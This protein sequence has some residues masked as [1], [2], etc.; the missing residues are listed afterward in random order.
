MDVISFIT[1]LFENGNNDINNLR[2]ELFKYGIKTVVDDSPN[3]RI[4]LY[5][6]RYNH[7]HQIPR[8]SNENEVVSCDINPGIFNGL[9]L[10]L[11]KSTG[12]WK[13]CCVPQNKFNYSNFSISQEID[14]NIQDNL[15]NIYELNDGT[16]INLYWWSE[17]W[18]ISTTRGIQMN[19]VEW[20]HISYNTILTE[21]LTHY[22]EFVWDKLDKNKTY[23]IGFNHPKFHQFNP[24]GHD[25]TLF[26]I[27]PGK[28]WF[29]QSV[30]NT[31][32][33]IN[34][35]DDIKLP[36]Q[37]L[38]NHEGSLNQLK[39]YCRN[40][41]D[42]Y[43]DRCED[44]KENF[45]PHFGFT[46]VLKD[47]SNLNNKSHIMI[48]SSLFNKIKYYMYSGRYKKI[49]DDKNY[50]RL[51]YIILYSYLTGEVNDT[52]SVFIKLFPQFNLILEKYDANINYIINIIAKMLS[53]KSEMKK[54][55]PINPMNILILKLFKHVIVII[56][57]RNFKTRKDLKSEIIKYIIDGDLLSYYYPVFG[58][59]S[60]KMLNIL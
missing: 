13:V 43:I 8:H 51:S 20:Q 53:H 24:S 4:I 10:C 33:E 57:G 7:V 54:I 15:Y 36:L 40:S 41:M 44:K 25:L 28:L 42:F 16:T 60:E 2:S 29:I 38:W 56:G 14:S 35:K 30:H 48:E 21:L 55:K 6:D 26:S 47:L 49:L 58:K 39:Q 19:D 1:K 46:L 37:K 3:I 9:I 52:N 59:E 17:K 5:I 18:I 34:I 22:P 27:M 12:T 11:D 23:T 31:T 50:E 45:A 32:F